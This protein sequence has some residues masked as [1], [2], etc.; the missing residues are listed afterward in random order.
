MEIYTDFML[1]QIEELIKL[2]EKNRLEKSLIK[3]SKSFTS[4]KKKN[5]DSETLSAQI[6]S[7]HQVNVENAGF[8]QGSDPGLP[9]AKAFTEGYLRESDIPEKLLARLEILIQIMKV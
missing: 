3:L 4:W 6:R 8:T 7:W 5:I 1:K 2:A 9:V